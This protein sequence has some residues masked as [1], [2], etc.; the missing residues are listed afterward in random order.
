M[1][2]IKAIMTRRSIRHFKD[3]TVEEEKIETLLRTAMQA[4]SAHNY[5]PWHFIVITERQIL[6]TI[7]EFHPHAKML[8]EAPAAIMICG[9]TRLEQSV[10]YINTDCAAA[11]ENL[12]LAAHDLGMGAVWLGI[13]PRERRVQEIRRLLGIPRQIIPIT[14]IALGY[15]AEEKDV[16]DR[17]QPERVHRNRWGGVES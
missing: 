11:A 15:A 9:D 2:T 12:L 8:H 16:E 7:P 3:R 5:Q 13:Y 6:S 4:P 1:N 10:E 14:L 17:F